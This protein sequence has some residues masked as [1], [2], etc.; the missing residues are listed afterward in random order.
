MLTTELLR[1][2]S[3]R[4]A[5]AGSAFEMLN[6]FAGPLLDGQI[7]EAAPH[8]LRLFEVINNERGWPR[9]LTLTASTEDNPL[10]ESVYEFRAEVPRALHRVPPLWAHYPVLGPS[11]GPDSRKLQHSQAFAAENATALTLIPLANR[12]GKWVGVVSATWLDSFELPDDLA[13]YISVYGPLLSMWFQ[14]DWLERQVEGLE[15]QAPSPD[16]S[17]FR[18]IILGQQRDLAQL[19]DQLAEAENRFQE[20]ANSAP[21]LVWVGDADGQFTFINSAFCLYVGLSTEA[22]IE[23]GWDGLLHPSQSENFQQTYREALAAQDS[24]Q[25]EIRLRASGGQYRWHMCTAWPRSRPDGTFYGFVGTCNDIHDRIEQQSDLEVANN[26]LAQSVTQQSDALESANRELQRMAA[27]KDEFLAS[28]SHEIRTPIANLKLYH[29]LLS[30]R[31]EKLDS[32]VF[33]LNRETERLSSIVDELIAVA[34]MSKGYVSLSFGTINLTELVKQYL[35]DRRYFTEEH[36]VLLEFYPESGLPTIRGDALQL[37]RALGILLSNAVN[38]TVRGDRIAVYTLVDWQEGQQWVGFSVVDNGPGIH[39]ADQ[40]K[41]FEPFFRGEA[42]REANAPGTGLG[43]S[44]LKEIVLQHGGHIDLES[45]QNGT[46]FTV[47]LPAH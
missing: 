4:F 44:I 32:Y 33:T 28:I 12:A 18:Q 21:M 40:E 22:L 42:S 46:R 25:I 2:V 20:I 15:Q 34:D 6:T 10:V 8:V 11:G 35:K 26:A 13:A 45:D 43:L 27:I 1:T 30:S 16:E 47:W 9:Q 19:N 24:F 3:R 38:Y 23:T 37:E 41:L 31:P 36:E 17:R 39:E 14:T 5:A 7:T 29:A